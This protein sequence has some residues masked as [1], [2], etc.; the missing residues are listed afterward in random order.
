MRFRLTA[1]A[2]I[3]AA[4]AA[5]GCG[6][7]PGSIDISPKK[8]KIYGIERAQRLTA[9]VLDRKGQP[10]DGATPTW[11][12][13]GGVVEA[14]AGGRVVAKKAGKALVTAAFGDVSAQVPVEVVDVA[15][16]DITPPALSLTGPAGTSLPISYAVKD[17]HQKP[18]DMKPGWTSSNPKAATISEDGVVTSVGPG[19]TMIIG[20]IG[21]I[22]GGSDVTVA[23]R[24]IDHLELRPATALAR[25]GE[26]QHFEVKAFGPDGQPISDVAAVFKSSDQAVASID[27]AG[28][29]TG[30]KAGAAKIRVELAGKTAESTLLVN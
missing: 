29:A 24:P 27:G 3:A 8:V 30:K 28:V 23:I 18:V 11:S 14:E 22:Q 4:I 6:R 13:S 5:S 2:L 12:A 7:K 10:L 1:L 17:S 15:A 21:D 25:V 9:R 16:I 26:T 19:T 20:K